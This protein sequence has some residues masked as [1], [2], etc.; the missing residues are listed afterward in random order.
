MHRKLVATGASLAGVAVL[1]GAF[2]THALAG[3]LGPQ[4]L[5]WWQTAIQYQAWHA[6]GIFALGLS[7]PDWTR[8]P[9]WLLAAGVLIFATTLYAM[10]LGAP[11]WLG[12][13]TP[14][15]GLLMIAGWGLLVWQAIS[16]RD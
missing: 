4:A 6:I 5:G 1:L 12:A 16:S 10:A 7:G 8:R 14:V 2:G 15:G 9:A 3:R 13:V 11:R